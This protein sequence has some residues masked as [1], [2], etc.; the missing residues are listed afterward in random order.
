[1][2]FCPPFD[3]KSK[4]VQAPSFDELMAFIKNMPKVY[5]DK[6]REVCA[7]PEFKALSED[8]RNKGRLTCAMM[9][10]GLAVEEGAWKP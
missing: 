2:P 9:F 4:S 8:E 1:M 3:E 5:A 6:M 10:Y 7:D